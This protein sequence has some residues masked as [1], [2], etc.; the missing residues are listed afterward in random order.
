[1]RGTKK[2]RKSGVIARIQVGDLIGGAAE[3][4]IKLR[5][6]LDQVPGNGAHCLITGVPAENMGVR[7]IVASL[8]Q[9]FVPVTSI[10]GLV[11][12]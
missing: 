5:V 12:E 6:I 9:N 2:F 4:S 11:N 7:M 8:F 10:E 3:D 1:M